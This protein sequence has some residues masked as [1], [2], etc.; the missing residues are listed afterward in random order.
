MF[1]DILIVWGGE[2]GCILMFQ[3]KGGLGCD[4]YIKG[5]LMWMV[6][7]GIC[8]GLI[9]GVMDEFGYYLIEDVVYVCDFYVMM[10]YLF[11]IDYDCFQ[12]KY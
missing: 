5:F 3:G 6:G 9:Y 7:G 2:F 12:V 8:G 1:E 10:L 11:G 4:Y